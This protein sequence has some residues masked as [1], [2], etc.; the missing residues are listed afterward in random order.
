MG[1]HVTV[2]TGNGGRYEFTLA[3]ADLAGLDARKAQG[4]LREE[5]EKAGCV[6][7]NPVGKLLLADKILCLAKTRQDPAYA[8]PT[9][10]VSS[11]VRAAAVAMGGSM[12]IDLGR[13]ALGH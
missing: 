10:W 1:C 9:P 4:W 5:F 3:D 6:P 11:F 7:T 13:H 12:T 2:V 8:E